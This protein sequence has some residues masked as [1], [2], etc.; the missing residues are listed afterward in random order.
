MN[1]EPEAV[2]RHTRIQGAAMR[3]GTYNTAGAEVAKISRDS[4]MEQLG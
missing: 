3:Q 1:L 2:R 4:F